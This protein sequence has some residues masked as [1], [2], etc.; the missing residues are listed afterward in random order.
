ME[1]HS[2]SDTIRYWAGPSGG[3]KDITLNS[4]AIEV[5]T[6]SSSHAKEIKISSLDQLDRSTEK[7]YL[8]HL[9]I[10]HADTEAGLTLQYLYDFVGSKI[11]DDF[12]ASALFQRTA[13]NIFNK[14]SSEQKE[15]P[16]LCSEIDMYDVLDAFPKLIRSDVPNGVVDANY[17]LSVSSI[18]SFRV[19]EN[20]EDI[21][22]NG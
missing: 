7:L 4:L 20:L 21:I 16:Y 8:M 12:T 9:S 5:K 6:T 18:Q 1:V 19:T 17:S 3:K 14:A 11:K 2:P 13:G 10:S 15:E 22:K